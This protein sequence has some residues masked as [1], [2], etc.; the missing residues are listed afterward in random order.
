[1]YRPIGQHVG[2][3]WGC[4]PRKSRAKQLFRAIANF[5]GQQPA[6][7][8]GSQEITPFDLPTSKTLPVTKHE[9]DQNDDPLQRYGQLKFF[10]VTAW[11]AVACRSSVFILLRS[12]LMSYP[13]RWE[14]VKKVQVKT[15]LG[16]NGPGKKG[17][18]DYLDSR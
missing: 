6:A 12:T 5:F 10:K 9:M 11:S 14:P 4:S 18:S 2:V 15:V 3:G 16:K 7:K 1:M 17:P 8:Y 13:H